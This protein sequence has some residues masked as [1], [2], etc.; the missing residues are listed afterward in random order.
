[1]PG[2]DGADG[3]AQANGD[4]KLTDQIVL[5]S[6]ALATEG[7]EVARIAVT[8]AVQAVDTI[9]LAT[10]DTAESFVKSSPVEPMAGPG[11][12]V[13]RQVWSTST[14]TVNEVLAQV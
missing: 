10:L 11:I 4:V 5:S 12:E 2:T 1:M 6:A 13:A 7:I 9:V 14:S 3:Q 8:G